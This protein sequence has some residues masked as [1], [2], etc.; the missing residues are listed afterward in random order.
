MRPLSRV[1]LTEDLREI[2]GLV[3][4]AGLDGVG[5]HRV[6]A[7]QHLLAFTFHGADQLRQVITDFVGTHAYD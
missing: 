2:T 1:N 5:V 4:A 6:A 3:T 7:P